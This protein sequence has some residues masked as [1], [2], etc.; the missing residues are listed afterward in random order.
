MNDAAV[1]ATS[2]GSAWTSSMAAAG[3]TD[4]ETSRTVPS[5]A[6]AVRMTCRTVYRSLTAHR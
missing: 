6:H 2:T 4:S 3:Q 1:M 5:S